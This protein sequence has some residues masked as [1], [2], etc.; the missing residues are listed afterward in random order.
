MAAKILLD[1]GH[2]SILYLAGPLTNGSQIERQA[3]MMEAVKEA[4]IP[5]SCI[6]IIPT[7][8][9]LQ[10]NEQKQLS[11]LLLPLT[12]TAI[13]AFN[14]ERGYYAMHSL[15]E[16]GIQIPE[17]VSIISFDNLHHVVKYLPMI[18]SI[19]HVS[20][21]DIA[22]AAAKLLLDLISGSEG[23]IPSDNMLPVA[24]HDGGTLA[25]PRK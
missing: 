6:R 19:S 15:K 3:G 22:T 14:D 10:M 21:N 12:Y 1:L 23:H 20:G 2:R 4:G 16:E 9:F 13:I 18:S 24:L 8:Q 17:Q 25:A 11:K 5:E 7:E